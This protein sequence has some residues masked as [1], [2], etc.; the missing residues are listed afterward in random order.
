VGSVAPPFDLYLRCHYDWRLLQ[1]RCRSGAGVGYWLWYQLLA[2]CDRLRAFADIH[3][4]CWDVSWVVSGSLLPHFQ[5]IAP[6]IRVHCPQLCGI[7]FYIDTSRAGN[8]NSFARTGSVS[9]R[10]LICGGLFNMV[11]NDDLD[12]AS[13]RFEFQSELL[14]RVEKSWAYCNRG[15]IRV[16]CCRYGFAGPSQ[17][18]IELTR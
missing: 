10:S 5:F 12:R 14:E 11:N 9:G 6:P 3:G 4:F 1:G 17:F 2:F 8:E 13:G 7:D 18:N 16:R 15:C